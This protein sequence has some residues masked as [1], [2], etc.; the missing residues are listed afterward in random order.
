M[1]LSQSVLSH[2]AA[3]KKYKA[4]KKGQ[5]TQSKYYASTA[6]KQA[7]KRWYLKGNNR[8]KM[9]VHTI[10]HLAVKQG[11]LFKDLCEVCGSNNAFAHHDDYSKPLNVRWLCNFHHSEYHRN[12]SESERRRIEKSTR[13]A[14]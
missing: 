13:K 2:R 12:L 7:N 9:Y 5:I 4:S 10:T 14:R 11:K 1:T 6:K 8:V 3:Q